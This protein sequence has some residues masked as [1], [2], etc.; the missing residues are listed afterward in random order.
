MDLMVKRSESQLRHIS[1]IRYWENLECDIWNSSPRYS[2]RTDLLSIAFV[3]NFQVFFRKI[4]KTLLFLFLC[5][6]KS[7]VSPKAK[8]VNFIECTMYETL[9]KSGKSV[10]WIG[11]RLYLREPIQTI[12]RWDLAWQKRKPIPHDTDVHFFPRVL[13][14]CHREKIKRRK[15][16]KLKIT[17][18]S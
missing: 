6:G 2:V 4:N 7:G 8:L 12:I 1:E 10:V 13:S 11:S 18:E 9:Q 14:S 15:S 16:I 3:E 17:N 5:F